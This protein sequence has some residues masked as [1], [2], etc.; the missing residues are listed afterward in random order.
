MKAAEFR[1]TNNGA[2][3]ADWRKLA[4]VVEDELKALESKQFVAALAYFREK[5]PMRQDVVDNQLQF[6]EVAPNTGNEINDLLVYVCRVRNNLF[7]G[8]KFRGQVLRNPGSSLELIAHASVILE[9]CMDASEPL[10]E[11]YELGVV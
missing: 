3:K 8:G 2:A 10:K 5:P 1:N 9:A 6:R 7:H 11:A 4:L